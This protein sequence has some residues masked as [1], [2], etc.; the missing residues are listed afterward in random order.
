VWLMQIEAHTTTRDFLA[1]CAGTSL[2]I[3]VIMLD[4]SPRKC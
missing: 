4:Q 1:V 2:E 3:K